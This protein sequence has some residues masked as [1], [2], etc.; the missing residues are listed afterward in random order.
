MSFDKEIFVLLPLF[1]I[2]GEL[3]E[4]VSKCACH[5]EFVKLLLFT[6]NLIYQKTKQGT[7]INSDTHIIC[8]SMSYYM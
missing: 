6:S 5:G 7:Y 1:I 3:E 2:S 4:N 8:Q